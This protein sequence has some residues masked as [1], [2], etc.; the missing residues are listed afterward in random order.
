[1]FSQSAP[2]AWL[3]FPLVLI[4]GM[5]VLVSF[6]L[7]WLGGWRGLAQHYRL[8]RGG[9]FPCKHL[10]SGDMG[11][12]EYR[13]CLTVGGDER[14]LYLATLLP[15]RLGHPPLCIPWSDIHD[16]RRKRSF[17]TNWDTFEL[18]PD[19]VK[20]RV[21]SSATAPLERYLPAVS[22]S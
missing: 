18:G 9:G 7:S 11:W 22:S 2:H 5:L 13:S 12:V 20:L 15:F 19:R 10:V 4:P 6:F 21:Q 16:R 1:M 17:F 14:G 8:D 3:W